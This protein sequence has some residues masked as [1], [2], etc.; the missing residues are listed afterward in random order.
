MKFCRCSSIFN[1]IRRSDKHP[2]DYSF[3]ICL[4]CFCFAFVCFLS[5]KI[6]TV[7]NHRGPS[8]VHLAQYGIC[9]W[10]FCS[11]CPW[12]EPAWSKAG[13]RQFPFFPFDQ[14]LSKTTVKSNLSNKE[15]PFFLYWYLLQWN[16]IERR[17]FSWVYWSLE[18]ND[19][20]PRQSNVNLSG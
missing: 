11:F 9:Y 20:A 10:W 5:Y 16:W 2:T 4:F 3:A 1:W 8:V 12:R 19:R 13:W 6:F 7:I 18:A 15:V 14:L 17:E